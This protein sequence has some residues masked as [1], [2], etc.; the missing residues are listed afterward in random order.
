[1][2]KSTLPTAQVCKLAMLVVHTPTSNLFLNNILHVPSATKSLAFVHKIAKDNNVYLEFHSNFFVIKDKD[3]KKILYH[4]RCQGGLYPLSS[5]ASPRG[6]RPNPEALA[7]H[8]PSTSLWHSRLGHPAIPIVQKVISSN[9]LPCASNKSVESVCDSC[10]R[11]KSRQLPYPVSNKISSAPLE[12]IYSDVWGPAPTSVGRHNYYVSFID[13]YSKYTWIYLLRH[14][15]D[16]FRVFQ[17]FQNLI[18][19]KLSRKILC[20]QSDWGGEYEKLNSL[21]NW[22]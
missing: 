22:Y 14:K 4:G 8:T 20:I 12:L 10:Q 19:R 11:A 15:S 9:S 18:E 3:T 21:E 1:M 5:S 7:A 16:V 2:T 6:Q 13:D 17:D